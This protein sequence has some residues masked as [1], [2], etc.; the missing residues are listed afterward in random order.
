VTGEGSIAIVLRFRDLVTE[1]GG[2]IAE[3]RRI[4][5]QRGYVW[6]AWWRRQKEFVPRQTLASLFSA[7]GPPLPVLLFDSGGL[8]LFL[9]SARRVVVAPSEA[10][11]HA[12]QVVATP[13][14]YVRGQYPAWFQFEGEITSVPDKSVHVIGRPTANSEADHIPSSDA[15]GDEVPL[16]KLQ[17]ERP[18]LWLARWSERLLTARLRPRAME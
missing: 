11:V 5:R 10:G 15:T 6:W 17:D 18:T 12:P 13:E 9:T 2:T 1:L 14:Y 16:D 8:E 4:L 3:H 7:S